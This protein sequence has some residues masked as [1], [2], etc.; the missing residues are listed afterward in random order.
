MVHALKVQQEFY[1]AVRNATKKFEVRKK[2]RNFK[3]GDYLA[4]NELDCTNTE[5]TGR[6]IIVKVTY[7]LDDETYCKKDF[8]I[9]AFEVCRIQAINETDTLPKIEIGG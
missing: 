1:E 3:L 5:Y 8:V 7:I 4:L 2:D 9:L 6:S